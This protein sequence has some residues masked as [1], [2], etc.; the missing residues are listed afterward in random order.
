MFKN[1]SNC[2]RLRRRRAGRAMLRAAALA[3]IGTVS[4]LTDA[5]AQNFTDT[6]RLDDAVALAVAG[7]DMLQAARLR[8]DVAAE[9]V[10]RAGAWMNP[11]LTLALRNRPIG[12]FA[13][14]ERMTM[15]VVEV[16]QQI[17]W[18]GKLGYAKERAGLLAEASLF[19]ADELSLQLA[20]RVK[21]AYYQIAFTDRAIAIME[22][23]RELLRGF[24]EVSSTQYA[25][26]TGL[27]QDV[28]QA[29]IAVAQMTEN[30][31][32]M[33]Q[34]RVAMAARLNALLG[35]NPTVPIPGLELPGTLD[36]LAGVEV[37][38]SEAAARRPAL[39]AIRVRTEAAEAGYRAARR[40]LYPDFMLRVAY[41]QR[42]QFDDMVT[43]MVGVSVPIFASSRQLPL[44]REMLAT[45]AMEEA[46]ER[47]LYNE[48]FARVTELRAEAERAR[49]L[50]VLY[51]NA[52]LPQARAAVESA[53]SAYRVG[54]VDYS[55]LVQNEMT[56]NRYEIE[57]VRLTA[58]YH[59]AVAELE[60]LVGR[61]PQEE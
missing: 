35:R 3:A 27:Q 24:Q 6:L 56:V 25:V 37:L 14:D 60:A 15:N 23:T 30:I 43:L 9:R 4:W 40:A 45:Q 16:G 5:A 17:P 51:A 10:P 47:D 42:P 31:Y 20:A 28:L 49:A 34:N 1:K 38:M 44:R 41:G 32:V 13:T 61:G 53:L 8:V 18:P 12:D 39:A 50:S 48:T 36:E 26:G 11:Q 59:R 52:V 57:S 2:A 46:R 33:R 7:N 58:D 21:G 55:T 19:E 54:R 29:Q 22:G